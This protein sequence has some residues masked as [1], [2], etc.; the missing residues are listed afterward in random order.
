MNEKKMLYFALAYLKRGFS[1]IPVKGPYYASGEGEE[2]IRD[3]KSPL[4]KWSEYRKRKPAED[5]LKKWFEQFPYANIAVVTGEISGIVVIDFDSEEKFR[6]FIKETNP[7]PTPIVKTSRGYHI[8]FKY[9]YGKRIPCSS[10]PD[11]DIRADG[12]YVILPPSVHPATGERYRF[13]KGNTIEIEPAPLPDCLI[14]KESD[15]ENLREIYR[16]VE[17]GRRNTSLARLVG[18]WVSDG[19]SFEECMENALLW[20]KKNTPPLELDEVERTVRSI[21]RRHLIQVRERQRLSFYERNLLRFP[22]ATCSRDKIH[23]NTNIEINFP[24]GGKW[25]VTGSSKY[26]IPGPFDDLVFMALMKIVSEMSKPV[27]NPVNIG[28]LK[29]IALMIRGNAGSKD[30]E[31]IRC[32]L[33]RLASVTVFSQRVFYSSEKKC[34]ITDI[35]H[36]FD[37]V[38]FR[39]EELQDGSTSQLNL[40]WLNH[41][42]LQNINSGYTTPL[43]FEVYRSLQTFAARA[44]YKLLFPAFLLNNRAPITVRYRTICDRCQIQEQKTLSRAKQQ[45]EKPHE[46][47]IRWKVISSAEW[48]VRAGGISIRYIP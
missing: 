15:E 13:L 34:F 46:E 40:V 3:A 25:L 36:I 14:L 27:R 47:L 8:Y 24:D 41:A 28:S 43:D 6:K 12:G 10:G 9:P 48:M 35:F 45:L 17:K 33:K 42:I 31:D 22:I 39:G 18:S 21:F 1:V 44:I 20:N 7:P 30:I 23:K 2:R 5:E 29:R 26:G 37:R 4:V 19:L 16:G 38:R 32:S 11:F